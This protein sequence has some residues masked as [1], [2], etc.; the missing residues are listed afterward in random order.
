MWQR[1]TI[2]DARIIIHYLGILLLGSCV[3]MA[4]SLVVAI[5]F[6]EWNPA[7]RYLSAIGCALI[8]GS[9]MSLVYVHPKKLSHQ[10]AVGVTA[11]AWIALSFLAA[12]PLFYSGHYL[13]YTDAVFDSVSAFTTTGATLITD[14]DHLSYAD[15][16]MRFMMCLTG[17]LGIIVVALSLGIFGKGTSTALFTGEGR[18]EHVIPNIV[19]ATRFI[20]KMT[21]IVITITT[22]SLTCL[23]LASGMEFSRALLHGFWMAITSFVTG[24]VAPMSDSL[25]YYNSLSIEIVCMVVMLTGAIS[26]TLIYFLFRGKTLT[27]FKD[28]EVKTGIIWMALMTFVFASSATMSQY[29][30]SLPALVHRGTFTLVSAFTTT[31]LSV[32]TQNQL[33]VVL[34]SGAFVA[35]ALIMAIG[36]S[37]GSTAGGIKLER[38]GIIARSIVLSVKQAVSPNTARVS[39]RY[40]HGTPKVLDSVT[41]KNAMTIFILFVLTY[42]LGTLAGIAS[43]YDATLSMFESVALTSNTGITCGIVVPGMPVSLEIL[44]I[45]LM[46][47]GRLEFIA[48]LSFLAQ[49]IASFKPKRRI[50]TKEH[51]HLFLGDHK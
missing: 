46:W 34:T 7:L 36:A 14:L 18:T 37:A 50:L 45:V 21:I 10:Q 13:S 11:L 43:G 41:V 4:P 8:I 20:L 19:L 22:F 25:M 26:F 40:F 9:I 28:L 3:I 23:M 32:V 1:F 31:G 39:M 12:I 47:G 51:K 35:I 17:G 24:G 27:F 2:T 42:T 49:V 44:Y 38:L 6:S 33:N 29:F 30:N 48:L 5:I 15:N 16:M